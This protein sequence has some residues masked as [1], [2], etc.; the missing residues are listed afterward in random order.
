MVKSLRSLP[1]WRLV[2]F[3]Q[4]TV[5]LHVQIEVSWYT[6]DRCPAPSKAG[7]SETQVPQLRS[8]IKRETEGTVVL[9]DTLDIGI[10]IF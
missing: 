2:S 9:H 7:S 6:V 1:V 10:N 4:P 5:G 8:G 3:S